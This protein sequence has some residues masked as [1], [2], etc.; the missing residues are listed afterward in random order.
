MAVIAKKRHFFVVLNY[1]S[2]IFEDAMRLSSEAQALLI[3][4]R[5]DEL[6]KVPF[7]RL[8]HP[9]DYAEYQRCMA[10]PLSSVEPE[11]SFPEALC[12]AL[13]LEGFENAVVISNG[14]IYSERS[15]QA[16]LVAM[17]PPA[18]SFL[19]PET[20][21]EIPIGTIGPVEP[22]RTF[23]RLP[24]IDAAL[25]AFRR[26]LEEAQKRKAAEQSVSVAVAAPVP[27]VSET[28]LRSFSIFYRDDRGRDKKMDA[29]NKMTVAEVKRVIEE[30][31]A[32]PIDLQRLI[33]G[34]RQLHEDM[35]TLEDYRIGKEATIHL[36]VRNR[37]D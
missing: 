18:M 36:V 8:I 34:G 22:K 35:R 2:L 5:I 12:D 4:N 19:C 25:E 33:H 27:S 21:V 23:V 24:Q 3:A 9:E 26:L 7:F 15:V 20:R 28:P 1:I 13:S 30:R 6:E 10:N 32:V 14:Q 17:K 11:D 29:T 31:E 16:L 37:G